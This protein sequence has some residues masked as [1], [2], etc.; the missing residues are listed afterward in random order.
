MNNRIDIVESEIDLLHL[1]K[2]LWHKAWLTLL[3]LLLCGGIAFSCAAFFISPQYQSR[4][5]MYVSNTSLSAEN[6]SIS[7]AELSAA[8]SLLDIYVIVLDSRTVLESVIEK[9]E[10]DCTYK[11]LSKMI[12]AGSVDST[13]VLEIVVTGRDPAETKRI[14]DTIVEILPERMDEIVPGS[15]VYVVDTAVLPTEQASPDCIEY[16]VIGM[17]FGFAASCIFLIGKELAS[18]NVRSEA[19]LTE[20][21]HLPILAVLPE[22]KHGKMGIGKNLDF[23]ALEAYNRLR[24]NLLFHFS[25]EK[26]CL[27]IGITSSLR[28][29]GKSSTS[30]NL[31]YAFAEA[32]KRVLLLDADMRFSAVAK[33]AGVGQSPGLSDLLKGF[34]NRLDLLQLSGIHKNLNVLSAGE[35]STNPTELLS[36]EKMK[37]V[38][39]LCSERFDVV[40]LDL[41]PVEVAADAQIVS[42]FLHGMIVVVRQNYVDKQILDSSIR[43][44]RYHDA[45]VL[46]FVLNRTERRTHGNGYASSH[47]GYHAGL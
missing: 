15:S 37:A 34:S 38:L 13:E 44:L 27:K 19:E 22:Q 45:N 12:T 29:E 30:V 2:V 9:A 18:N 46:G 17:L 31:A 28:G 39:N 23:T 4:A 40:L 47:F 11:E 41:P 1:M 14:V 35:I 20:K 33:Y 3:S 24:S 8:K 43:Q 7:Y 26:G 10:L 21:Y 5:M 16:T 25:G 6:T 42:E 32:G 36:S